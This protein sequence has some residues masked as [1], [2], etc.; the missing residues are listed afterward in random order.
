LVEK[1]SLL[2]RVTAA[3][4]QTVL[5]WFGSWQNLGQRLL[6]S[7]RNWAWPEESFARPVGRATRIGLDSS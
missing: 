4:G 1:G 2:R 3:W 7:L 5:G 6:E